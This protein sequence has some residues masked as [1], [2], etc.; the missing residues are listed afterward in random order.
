MA[1]NKKEV[2]FNYFCCS[3]KYAPRKE[4]K[5]PCNDCLNQPWNTDSHKPVNCEY[6]NELKNY[7][8]GITTYK[9][10]KT[11]LIVEGSRIPECY[12]CTFFKERA[13]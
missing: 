10:E 9:C 2:Y 1:E 6:A 8:A 12:A 7:K 4:S 3:C 13:V 5:D 11:G